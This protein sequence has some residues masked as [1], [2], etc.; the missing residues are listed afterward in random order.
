MT[1]FLPLQSFFRR[2]RLVDQNCFQ[3][4]QKTGRVLFFIRRDRAIEDSQPE[5]F[6]S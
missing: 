6:Q 1:Q 3:L 2:F 5:L 4:L